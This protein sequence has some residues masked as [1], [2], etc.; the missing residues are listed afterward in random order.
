MLDAAG[1]EIVQR[2]VRRA[3]YGDYLCRLG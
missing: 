1:F 2:D 3:V